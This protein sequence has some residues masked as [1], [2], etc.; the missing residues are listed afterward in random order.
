MDNTF[1]I[2]SATGV[3]LQLNVAGPGARSYAFVI[4]WHIRLLLAFA[5]FVA[6][7]FVVVGSLSFVDT[8]ASNFGLYAYLV[9]LPAAGIY[10][11][12]HPVLEIAMRGRTPGKR[13][14]GVRIVTHDAQEPG[15]LAHVIRNLLRLLDSLPVG[16]VIGLVSAFITKNAVRIGDIA[17][18]T[19]LIYDSDAR[20]EK[21]YRVPVNPA[22]IGRHGLAKAEL[23]QDLLSRWDQLKEEKR[24]LLAT[25]LLAT[26]EPDRQAHQNLEGLRQQLEQALHDGVDR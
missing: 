12:Y 19:V 4:D 13:M 10:F 25:K 15:V 7:H 26:L 5:W 23:V 1:E 20:D 11:L 14:A 22:V 6:L 18:G 16:Y 9:I 3:D 2:A 21:L 24:R 8:E 17:A